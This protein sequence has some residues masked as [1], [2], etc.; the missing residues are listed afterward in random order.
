[1]SII[2]DQEAAE[3]TINHGE[4]TSEGGWEFIEEG[5]LRGVTLVVSRDTG[6]AISLSTS[7]CREEDRWEKLP[8]DALRKYPSLEVLDL[9]KSIYLT[10][11]DASV[12]Q[13][14]DL[15]RLLLTRCNNLCTISPSIGSLQNLT[16]VS[17]AKCGLTLLGSSF[18]YFSFLILCVRSIAA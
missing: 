1:M 18:I 8:A 15:Q 4:R 7:S 12:C 17:A 5:S 14:P 13:L 9:H 2:I 6:N 10:E 3:I 16:E 11:F